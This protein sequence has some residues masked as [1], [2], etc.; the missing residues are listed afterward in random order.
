MLADEFLDLYKEPLK[1]LSFD[2]VKLIKSLKNENNRN[3]YEFYGLFSLDIPNYFI[4]IEELQK[5]KN[6][7][8]N[9]FKKLKDNYSVNFKKKYTK[10]VFNNGKLDNNWCFEYVFDFKPQNI[11]D[12]DFFSK[13]RMS[14][15][16]RGFGQ[17]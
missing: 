7:I 10:K 11:I 5:N 4:H 8:L 14:I 9:Y 15:I 2:K 1:K 17:F 3:Y 16:I 13:D 6:E 12:Y